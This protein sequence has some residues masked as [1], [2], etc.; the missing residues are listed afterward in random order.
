[1]TI[2]IVAGQK[3]NANM[4]MKIKKGKKVFLLIELT[5]EMVHWP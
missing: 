1:M 5:I 3:L 4:I 2:D